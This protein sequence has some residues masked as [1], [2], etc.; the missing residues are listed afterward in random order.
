[1]CHFGFYI[2]VTELCLS[3][4]ETF[5][6]LY[7]D[8][9]YLKAFVFLLPLFITLAIW[10]GQTYCVWRR[11]A[12]QYWVS[13]SVL[14]S[15]KKFTNS[16]WILDV[17]LDV[18]YCVV[19]RKKMSLIK[20][21]TRC[22]E[23]YCHR[24]QQYGRMNAFCWIACSHWRAPWMWVKEEQHATN[25][26]STGMQKKNQAPSSKP[27]V[28]LGPDLLKDCMFKKT[29]NW[30][31]YTKTTSFNWIMCYICCGFYI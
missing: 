1:M 21:L 23:P 9:C 19:L 2:P 16:V 28:Y 13:R 31:H 22:C 20:G 8:Q 3:S 14:Y 5:I 11:C 15:S 12:L 7:S 6:P 17:Y 30:Y 4:V 24:W 10:W 27:T 26:P 18:M 29:W 25:E